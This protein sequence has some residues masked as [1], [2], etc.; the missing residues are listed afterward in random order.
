MSRPRYLMLLPLM[1]CSGPA[2]R[3]GVTVPAA[4]LPPGELLA[5]YVPS[6]CTDAA[7]ASA[8]WNS[9][10]RLLRNASGE[11]I[12]V[13]L[14]PD[15]DAL[16]I[17]RVEV[18]GQEH[19]FQVVVRE[20]LREFRLPATAGGSGKMVVARQWQESSREGG[21]VATELADLVLQCAL[22]P[23]AATGA[24]TSGKQTDGAATEVAAGESETGPALEPSN[25]PPDPRT[26]Y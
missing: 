21:G 8:Q 10:L 12:L 19:V 25:G 9:E 3:G 11:H 5:S 24:E 26:G 23:P 13:E 18:P 7:G 17:R 4:Q 20:W 16:V 6:S 15:Q 1:A 22:V 2:I 14:R